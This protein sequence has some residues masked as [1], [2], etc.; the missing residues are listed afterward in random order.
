[1]KR[2]KLNEVKTI[3]NETPEVVQDLASGKIY[4]AGKEISEQQ[5]R[6]LKKKIVKINLGTGIKDEL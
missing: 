6:E 1:M 5:F 2:H 4:H 3:L